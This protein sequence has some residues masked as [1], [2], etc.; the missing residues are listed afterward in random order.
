MCDKRRELR[1]KR[2]ES[3]GFEK[4]KEVNSKIKRCMKKAKEK[5][6]G[7]QYSEIE[8]HFEEEQQ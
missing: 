7:K 4:C 3:E 6:I 8:E 2:F 5:W 1:K